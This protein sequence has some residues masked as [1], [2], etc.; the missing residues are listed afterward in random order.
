[1]TSAASPAQSEGV[2]DFDAEFA[3]LEDFADD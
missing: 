1:V 2:E 3:D